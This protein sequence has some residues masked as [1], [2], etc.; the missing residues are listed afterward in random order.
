VPV[1]VL[2]DALDETDEEFTVKVLRGVSV[3]IRRPATVTI[4][5][6]PSALST[7]EGAWHPASTD[8][9]AHRLAAAT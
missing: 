3:R 7:P 9:R 8:P 4:T 5:P 2:A 1:E 6:P